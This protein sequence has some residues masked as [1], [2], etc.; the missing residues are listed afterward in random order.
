MS[1]L[2]QLFTTH[3]EEDSPSISQKRQSKSNLNSKINNVESL[4]KSTELN[5]VSS[6]QAKLVYCEECGVE[7]IGECFIHGGNLTIALDNEL[8]S[9]AFLSLPKLL[10]LKPVKDDKNI[11]ATGVFAKKL[12]KARTLFGPLEAGVCCPDQKHQ[13]AGID[14]QLKTPEGHFLILDTSDENNCN[15]MIFVRPAYTFSQQNVAAFQRDEHIFFVTCK[16]IPTGVEL[17]VWYAAAYAKAIGKNIL[18]P[19][20]ADDTSQKKTTKRRVRKSHKVQISTTVP[21]CVESELDEITQISDRSSRT[22]TFVCNTCNTSFERLSLLDSHVCKELEELPD[23]IGARRRRER[24][25]K[26]LPDAPAL[27]VVEN[28]HTMLPCQ[29]EEA[30]G[31]EAGLPSESLIP[32]TATLLE[33]TDEEASSPPV[34]KRSRGRPRGSKKT[35]D[36]SKNLKQYTCTFCQ[37]MFN[38]KEECLAHEADSHSTVP[39]ECPHD[40]CEKSFNS[41]FKYQRHMIVHQKPSHLSCAFCSRTFNRIDHLKNHML[42]HDKNRD[43]FSC[44]ICGKVYLYKSTLLFHKAKH[45]A[46]ESDFLNCLVCSKV[47]NS[48]QELNVHL[49]THNRY[50]PPVKPISKLSCPKCN[51]KF[52]SSKDIRRHMVT[53]TKERSFLCEHCPQTFVRKDHLRRHYTFSHKKEFY[54]A[55]RKNYPFGCDACHTVFQKKEFFEYHLKSVHPQGTPTAEPSLGLTNK[56]KSYSLEVLVPPSSEAMDVLDSNTVH[57]TVHKQAPQQQKRPAVK[58]KVSLLK[59]QQSQLLPLPKS[60]VSRTTASDP[61]ARGTWKGEHHGV[62]LSQGKTIASTTAVSSASTNTSP[63]TTTSTTSS[64]LPAFE[65]PSSSSQNQM[66][67]PE[68]TLAEL[69]SAVDASLKTPTFQLLR[70][71]LELHD[72]RQPQPHTSLEIGAQAQ[73]ITHSDILQQALSL[74]QL[75]NQSQL[76]DETTTLISDNGTITQTHPG[77]TPQV[78]QQLHPVSAVS[79]HQVQTVSPQITERPQQEQL[80]HHIQLQQEHPQQITQQ[81][82]FTHQEQQQPSQQLLHLFHNQRGEK[83]TNVMHGIHMINNLNNFTETPDNLGSGSNSNVVNLLGTKPMQWTVVKDQGNTFILPSQQQPSQQCQQQQ[84]QSVLQQQQGF[85]PTDGTCII[86]ADGRVLRANITKP[87]HCYATAVS[88]DSQQL[89]QLLNAATKVCP[90]SGMTETL[91]AQKPQR[92]SGPSLTDEEA[93]MIMAE[94]SKTGLKESHAATTQVFGTINQSSAVTIAN[95][96][97]EQQQQRQQQQIQHAEFVQQQRLQHQQQQTQLQHLKTQIELHQKQLMQRQQ[98]L[99]L[100]QQK[101][102]GPEP[103]QLSWTESVAENPVSSEVSLPNDIQ[104]VSNPDGSLISAGP[105]PVGSNNSWV[106]QLAQSALDSQQPH[107]QPQIVVIPATTSNHV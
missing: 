72:Q 46:E 71:T 51:K 66:F 98:Q 89:S 78:L 55:E 75:N 65:Q 73:N 20:P 77:I 9:R 70:A 25:P 90:S 60:V 79:Q 29:A 27:V 67:N 31:E 32:T 101:Q 5:S 57:I 52:N 68:E 16:D 61:F 69:C 103:T 99:Q 54:L 26:V 91:L 85:N 47:F 22:S 50:K 104:F 44:G 53:H 15:W 30:N 48:K 92:I 41:K 106:L 11:K 100:Q 96:E 23:T 12:I 2:P 1:I 83:S 38:S 102:Q 6:E 62:I 84:Q 21:K 95:A 81:K 28:G 18:H 107:Q 59:Q 63:T 33:S 36:V 43:T 87:D 74:Q 3:P 76:P 45:V 42:V 105:G 37:Q 80:P 14:Y 94:I 40:G 86:T 24:L 58:A 56:S 82:L 7:N 49:K 34:L 10:A 88:I 19:V 4:S 39:Y 97:Q 17:R 64:N 13:C 35:S 93:T 8:P